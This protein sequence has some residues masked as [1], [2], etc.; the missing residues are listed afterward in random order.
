[1]T[2]SPEKLV[3]AAALRALRRVLRQAADAQPAGSALR[4]DLAL[5]DRLLLRLLLVCEIPA[6]VAASRRAIEA[7]YAPQVAELAGLLAAG[8][9]APQAA[10][11]AQLA[12]LTG[13]AAIFGERHESLADALAAERMSPGAAQSGGG[14]VSAADWQGH[15]ARRYP[16]ATP[17]VQSAEVL[18]GGRSKLTVLLALQPNKVLPTELIMRCDKPGSAQDTRVAVEYQVMGAVFRHGL[19]V[20]EPLFLDAGGGALGV[21]FMAMRRLPGSAPGSYWSSQGVAPALGLALAELLA[22]LHR[23]DASAVWPDA[24]GEARACVADML[25]GIA[26]KARPHGV[27]LSIGV[28]SG[29][30]WLR[31]ELHAIE[32]DAVVV[33]GDAHFG[34][35]LAVGETIAG[36]TDWEFAHAGHAAEDLAFCRSY[37]EAIMSWPDFMGRYRACGGREVSERQ[38]Q[39]FRLWGQLRNLTMTTRAL[40]NILAGAEPTLQDLSHV[41]HARPKLA[42][43]LVRSVAEGIVSEFGKDP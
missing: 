33:H 6:A 5:A 31:R 25:A 12:S 28:E 20:A 39:F 19:P 35:L 43:L 21:A 17:V 23:I 40:A 9:A 11:A 15:L 7:R 18:A 2:A 22:R 1:M 32:G 13:D 4:D 42:T 41:L 36:L 38:L 24:A 29:L 14:G 30:A 10:A 3:N 34:N 8:D 27:P 16:D 37:I 26:A